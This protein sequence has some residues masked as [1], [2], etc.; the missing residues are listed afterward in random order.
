MKTIDTKTVKRNNETIQNRKLNLTKNRIS[1]A[2]SNR[3]K[4]GNKKLRK[5]NTNCHV[6]RLRAAN[7]SLKVIL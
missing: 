3:D 1:K 2:N 7:C 5:S 6:L 4:T